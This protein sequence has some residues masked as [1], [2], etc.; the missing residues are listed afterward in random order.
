MVRVSARCIPLCFYLRVNSL[1]NYAQCSHLPV[2]FC[3]LPPEIK[4]MALWTGAGQPLNSVTIV[5]ASDNSNTHCLELYSPGV[6]GRILEM[7]K[8]TSI[9]VDLQLLARRLSFWTLSKYQVLSIVGWTVR[10][11]MLR[12]KQWRVELSQLM[13]RLGVYPWHVRRGGRCLCYGVSSPS[14]HPQVHLGAAVPCVRNRCAGGRQERPQWT[15]FLKLIVIQP[16]P[17]LPAS[18]LCPWDSP[19]KN[20]GLGC[21]VF[22]G[23]SSRLRNQIPVSCTAGGFF[24]IWATGAALK[25]TFKSLLDVFC[26]SETDTVREGKPVVHIWGCGLESTVK[27][28]AL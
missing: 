21:I 11:P 26:A 14:A 17:T 20:A 24:S 18:L 10:N 16:G 13:W 23:G 25:A 4:S 15:S 7:A 12:Y 27:C 2:E 22:S 9:W 1:R 28:V 19:G 5:R 3:Q 8:G 6:S